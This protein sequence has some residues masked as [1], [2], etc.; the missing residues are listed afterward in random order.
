MHTHTI[1]PRVPPIGGLGGRFKSAEHG[2]EATSRVVGGVEQDA[3]GGARGGGGREGGVGRGHQGRWREGLGADGSFFAS[4]EA[5]TQRARRAAAPR[6]ATGDEGP[7]RGRQTISRRD[8]SHRA[9]ILASRDA[10]SL[11]QDNPPARTAIEDT[12]S[13]L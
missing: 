8:H 9:K 11:L 5:R 1:S 13:R 4:N 12:L 6:R 7:P 3:S 10:A 2:G